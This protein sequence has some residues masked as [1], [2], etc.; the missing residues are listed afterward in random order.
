M[1][2]LLNVLQNADRICAQTKA[3]ANVTNTIFDLASKL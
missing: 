1:E 3:A 2:T